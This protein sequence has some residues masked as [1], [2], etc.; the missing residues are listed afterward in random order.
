MRK[1]GPVM[2]TKVIPEHMKDTPWIPRKEF[3]SLCEA[4]GFTD[5]DGYGKY[6]HD[7]RI[8]IFENGSH[9]YPSDILNE[10]DGGGFDPRFNFIL[11]FNR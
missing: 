9:V 8:Q 1:F 7:G 10:G 3:V 2:R 6:L 4:G 11:W 5:D